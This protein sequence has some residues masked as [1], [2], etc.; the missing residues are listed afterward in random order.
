MRDGLNLM[1][2]DLI[3]HVYD[4]SSNPSKGGKIFKRRF[5]SKFT[6]DCNEYLT[7]N[8]VIVIINSL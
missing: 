1:G 3:L 2:K 5:F 7:Y 4:L 6:V 8:F